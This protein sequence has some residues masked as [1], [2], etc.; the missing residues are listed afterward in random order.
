MDIAHHFV[1]YLVAPVLLQYPALEQ[2][3]PARPP[4]T[5]KSGFS[6]VLF[7]IGYIDYCP[8]IAIFKLSA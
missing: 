7:G 6:T 8:Y 5:T 4:L 3:Y 2:R 1:K